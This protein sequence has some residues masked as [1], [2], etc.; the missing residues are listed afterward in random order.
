MPRHSRGMAKRFE[1]ITI[2]P[3]RGNWLNVAEIELLALS[4]NAWI[5][6]LEISRDLARRLVFEGKKEC[7]WN[8]S[9][10]ESI[11]VMSQWVKVRQLS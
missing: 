7:D 3:R 6:R 10:I 5:V 11:K 2:H 9:D 8:Q 1:Y 4:S